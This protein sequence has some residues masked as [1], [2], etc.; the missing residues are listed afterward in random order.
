MNSES[1]TVFT[2]KFDIIKS[3]YLLF[4]LAILARVWCDIELN[5][6]GIHLGEVYPYRKF[7]S[8]SPP[9]SVNVF[10]L[11]L[12]MAFIGAVLVNT[13][14]IR[15]AAILIGLSYL[16]SLT[17]MYQNQK[18]LILFVSL[19][20]LVQPLTLK[21][22]AS[23]WFLRTQLIFIYGFS[24]L[25]KISA[26]FYNGKALTG[27]FTYLQSIETNSI[28]KNLLLLSSLPPL[29]VALSVM[30]LIIELTIPVI[31]IKKPQLAVVLVCLFHFS[32]NLLLKDILPFSII[33]LAL[34]TLFLFD[35]N[36]DTQN[37]GPSS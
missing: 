6:Q 11:E 7:I 27:T 4:S 33:M 12:L 16:L 29:P 18:V 15:S 25:Q 20:L 2:K 3:F 1:L 9:Y 35:L 28:L 19:S 32:I 5:R 14:W 17:Q 30:T 13:R 21:N 26:G 22:T 8:E 23:I 24:A 34:S 37:S 36:K 31:L 10:Y